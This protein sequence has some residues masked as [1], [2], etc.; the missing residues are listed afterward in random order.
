M[1]LNTFTDRTKV[2]ILAEDTIITGFKLT[3]INGPEWTSQSAY[4]EFNYFYPVSDSSDE[5]DVCETFRILVERK[6]VS[7][8]FLGR[9]AACILR[10]EI[11]RKK[12]VF[13]LILEIPEKDGGPSKEEM[14]VM[15]RLKE[16]V[17]TKGSVKK[18]K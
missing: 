14:E 5:K 9:K 18:R 13:P 1:S 4:G 11:E 12:N 7:M 6:E 8:I 16:I 2:A 10:Q 17:G 3:G 15:K